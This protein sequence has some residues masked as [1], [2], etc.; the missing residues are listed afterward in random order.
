M[1]N[2]WSPAALRN[3]A[4]F[5]V[6]VWWVPHGASA[7]GVLFSGR[8]SQNH[9][10]PGVVTMVQ[11]SDAMLDCASRLGSRRTLSCD[12][13]PDFLEIRHSFLI[14]RNEAG[15]TINR[16]LQRQYRL[17]PPGCLSG[18]C[19]SMNCVIPAFPDM[20]CDDGIERTWSAPDRQHFEVDGVVFERIRKE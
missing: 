5:L 19:S 10:G 8:L 9:D 15:D 12:F 17:R 4:I 14:W 16:T 6:A 11:Y 1:R 18:F 3:L 13:V 20:I 7:A 2:S